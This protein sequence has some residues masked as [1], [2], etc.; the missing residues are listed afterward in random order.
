MTKCYDRQDWLSFWITWGVVLSVYLFTLAPELTLESAGVYA[1]GAMY[2]S[3]CVQPGDPFWSIYAWLCIH[4]LPY[5]NVAWRIALSSAVAGAAASAIV[6]LLVSRGGSSLLERTS[7]LKRLA[8]GDEAIL[9][10]VCG[11]VAGM[12]L[13]FHRVFWGQ[14]VVSD[15]LAFSTAMF[16]LV[17]CLLARWLHEPNRRGFLYAACLC[18]GLTLNSRIS[19]AAAAPGLPFIVYFR[20]RA[21]GRDLF[22]AVAFAIGTIWLADRIGLLPEGP[23]SVLQFES[24]KG[25][26][27]SVALVAV[28]MFIRGIWKTGALLTRWKAA[29]LVC[30]FLAFGLSFCL[31]LPVASMSNPPMN[32]GYPRTIEGFVHTLGRGQY[33]RFHTVFEGGTVSAARY[34][35]PFK[36]YVLVSSRDLGWICLLVGLVP[37][38][39]IRR[40]GML[41]RRWILGMLCAGLVF[42]CVTSAVLNPPEILDGAYFGLVSW[43]LPQTH[44]IPAILSGYGLVLLGAILTNG[45]S[46]FPRLFHRPT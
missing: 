2:A 9:R 43:L 19:W 24:L 31:Y 6:A 13:G 39:F 21:I 17:L 12:S 29:G 25:V 15:S 46:R 34:W 14:A 32:W 42:A 36:A 28:F 33:E 18:F 45:L 44:V 35:G 41:A 26:F 20:K 27:E 1:T 8:A 23:A 38:L 11:L 16:C 4:L 37:F 5:S 30:L 40:M 3:G 10:V 7:G 22:F